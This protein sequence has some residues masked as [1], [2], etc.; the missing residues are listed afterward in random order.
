[1]VAVSIPDVDACIA[2]ML[3]AG[4]KYLPAAWYR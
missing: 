2:E 1:M 4:K 3:A